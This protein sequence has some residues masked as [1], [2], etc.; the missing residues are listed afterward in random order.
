MGALLASGR[1]SFDEV[2]AGDRGRATSFAFPYPEARLERSGSAA[3]LSGMI[4]V[5]DRNYGNVWTNIPRELIEQASGS[6]RGPRSTF[7][8]LA[9]GIRALRGAGFP[10]SSPSRSCPR[11]SPWPT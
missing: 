6:R 1:I 7:E 10:S 8:D 3:V 11:E 5:S 2:G 4:P 9:R